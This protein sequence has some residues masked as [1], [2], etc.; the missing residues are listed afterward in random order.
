MR[1][2]ISVALAILIAGVR[3]AAADSDLD[4]IPPAIPDPS[5]PT[6]TAI[7][8]LYLQNDLTAS[9][10]RGDL[11]APLPPPEPP[12]WEARL[13]LDARTRWSW[14]A[15]LN[16]VYSGRFNLR[17]ED[18][19]A[20]PSR[21]NV[22]HDLREA[23]LA[24]QG[25]NGLF[26]ELGRINLK[27]GVALG[28][29]PTDFFKTR[30]VVEPVSADP[31]VLRE[32]RLGTVLLTGQKIWSGASL[33]VALAP[34]LADNSLPYANNDLPGFNP[35]LDRTNARTR[36]LVK[37]SFDL[38]DDVSP[39]LLFY[40]EGAGAHAGLNATKGFGQAVVGYI[41]WAGGAR[42]SL[43]DD[44]FVDG[45]ATGVL[46]LSQAIPVSGRRTF[47]SDLA[48]GASYATKLG[49]T[50]DGEYDLHQ[51]AFS[52]ADWRNWF[53]A[54]AASRDEPFL[55]D[56]LW[57]IRGYADDQQ[58]PMARNSAFLRADWPH[59]FTRDLALAGFIDTDLRDGSGLAQFT[60]NCYL[61]P[62]WTVGALVDVDFGRRRSDFGSLPQQMSTL[63]KLSRYF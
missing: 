23:Y 31:T 61:S 17:A 16:F 62:Y 59:A 22:R 48:L 18:G 38:V 49:I 53:G 44:A 37:G 28:F 30:A 41:E 32:D 5:A 51:A 39:E 4:R 19:I 2:R 58:E 8:A 60:A 50:F 6:D 10:L 55:L 7:A 57:F 36:V 52:A 9:A 25:G 63:I 29:N 43:A 34:K 27:S 3:G 46:P 14:T 15:D 13:F 33:A 35:M 20:F 45:E 54:G 12:R 1:V 42:A 11:A 21:E 40:D 47:A 24:W 56:A 26:V